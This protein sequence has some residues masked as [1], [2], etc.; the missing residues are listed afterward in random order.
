MD[1]T[2]Y[3]RMAESRIE[4]PIGRTGAVSQTDRRKFAA[5]E[6]LGSLGSPLTTPLPA[7][8]LFLSTLTISFH[9]NAR[10]KCLAERI[11][12]IYIR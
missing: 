7:L 10:R 9:H 5:N 4:R 12:R 1:G 3:V 8:R 11:E 6:A 2:N